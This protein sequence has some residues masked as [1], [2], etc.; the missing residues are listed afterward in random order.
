MTDEILAMVQTQTLVVQ[1]RLQKNNKSSGFWMDSPTVTKNTYL[2][3][4]KLKYYQVS[5]SYFTITEYNII[6]F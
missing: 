2:Q 1:E 3:K 4:T 5:S 6:I